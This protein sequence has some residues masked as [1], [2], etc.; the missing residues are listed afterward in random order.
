M[1]STDPKHSLRSRQLGRDLDAFSK[2]DKNIDF[3]NSI[4]QFDDIY[5]HHHFYQQKNR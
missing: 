1:T 5:Y 3:L 2:D 4:F